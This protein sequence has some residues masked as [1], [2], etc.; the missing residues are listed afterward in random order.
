MLETASSYEYM[1]YQ[2]GIIMYIYRGLFC[3]FL[4]LL[5]HEN[6]DRSLLNKLYGPLHYKIGGTC[7]YN[8]QV[9]YNNMTVYSTYFS[10][11]QTR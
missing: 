7:V 4:C 5:L 2:N 11:Q 9:F 10:I 1:V 6:I 3:C 8:G